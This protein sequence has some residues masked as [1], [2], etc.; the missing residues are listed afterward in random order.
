MQDYERYAMF[1]STGLTN[2]LCFPALYVVYK[3]GMVFGFMIGFFTFF[4]S[5]MYHSLDSLE[6]PQVYITRSEWHKLDNIGSIMS[7]IYLAVFLMDNIEKVE[8]KYSS[9]Y[10][11]KTDRALCYFGLF[12]TL[13][14]QTK[15]PWD[16]ENTVV[17]V[18]IFYVALAFKLIFYRRPRI[19]YDNFN[20]GCLILG[21]GFF[22][23]YKGLDDDNDYLRIWHGIWH[24]CGSTSLFY[25]YQSL[26]KNKH[27]LDLEIDPGHIY[28][29]YSYFRT[30]LYIYS[31]GYF[32]NSN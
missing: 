5:L 27:L 21:F 8:G 10:E 1:I 11:G 28:Q 15:H 32:K 29:N 12:I 4:C 30:F 3:R 24:C 16:I 20:R 26:S 31:L 22:C 7:L 14:M 17:P 6:I 2:F 18:V 25:F 13:L 9:E 19:Y 23:F